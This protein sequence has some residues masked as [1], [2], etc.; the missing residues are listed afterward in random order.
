M[1][2]FW[3]RVSEADPGQPWGI[4]GESDARL[5]RTEAQRTEKMPDG[6]RLSV[7]ADSVYPAAPLFLR[8]QDLER[9]ILDV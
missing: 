9:Q 5:L 7:D 4:D 6:T 8:L 1:P 3:L 2:G